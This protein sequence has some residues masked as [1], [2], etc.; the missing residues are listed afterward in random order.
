MGVRKRK[1]DVAS[2]EDT[3]NTLNIQLRIIEVRSAV[4]IS[5]LYSI[6]YFYVPTKWKIQYTGTSQFVLC[7][8]KI[9]KDIIL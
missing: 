2:N 4:I 5:R 9:V 1:E 8:F 7:N 6:Y 3:R